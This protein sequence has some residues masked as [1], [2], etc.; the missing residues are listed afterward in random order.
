MAPDVKEYFEGAKGLK[1]F[2]DW[3]SG[4]LGKDHIFFNQIMLFMAVRMTC[5]P[6]KLA[7]SI[8]EFIKN[9]VFSHF[10]FDPINT[11]KEETDE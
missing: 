6:G 10:G 1:G 2:V 7:G 3:C 11:D 4:N 9:T 8:D 5:G